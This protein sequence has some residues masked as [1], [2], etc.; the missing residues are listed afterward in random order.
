MCA[1]RRGRG[2]D[3][4]RSLRVLHQ[5]VQQP[6]QR[7]RALTAGHGSGQRRDQ[8][9]QGRQERLAQGCEVEHGVVLVH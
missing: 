6:Q 3:D 9:P 5:R 2:D 8:G 4:G 7:G 1:G